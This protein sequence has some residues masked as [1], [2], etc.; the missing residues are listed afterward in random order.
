MKILEI[1]QEGVNDQFL[2]HGVPDG[3]TMMQILKSGALEPQ[4]AF[5]FDRDMDMEK[6]DKP[7]KRI[8]L[9][10]NQYLHFPYGN[11]VA[12]FVVDKDALRRAGYKVV[13]K[14][15]AMMDYK[16]ETEEQVYKPIPI[17]APFIV[18][19]QYDPDLKIPRGF[20]DN[21]KRL[22]VKVTPWRK[23]GRNPN[24]KPPADTGPQPQDK[25]TDIEKLKIHD[26]GYTYGNPVVK[27][28]PTEWFVGYSQDGGIT[29]IIGPR[30][31]DKAYIQKLYAQI[32]DRVA[33]KLSFDDLLP[34][35]QFGKQWQSGY[36]E[37]HPGQPGWQEPTKNS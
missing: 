18:E 2:Y 15:G 10:R 27:V 23:E 35:R 11:G 30:S 32:K 36:R 21:A 28:E 12:Q 29:K 17:K 3:R 22:G 6:G 14:V 1:I 19:I 13:P 26:N 24:A 4:E 25:F 16:Y 33:K 37:I 34:A 5:D 20:L 7:L 31:T 9:T 8:S